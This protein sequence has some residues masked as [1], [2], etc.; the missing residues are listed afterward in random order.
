[1]EQE[2]TPDFVDENEELTMLSAVDLIVTLAEDSE[3][4][5]ISSSLTFLNVIILYLFGL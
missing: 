4:S 5:S 2:L 3:L 1:M